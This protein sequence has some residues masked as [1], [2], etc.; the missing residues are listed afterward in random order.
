LIDVIVSWSGAA[1]SSYSFGLDDPSLPVFPVSYSGGAGF[2]IYET[3]DGAFV[4]GSGVSNC[5]W[6]N[7]Q[8]Q[9]S[10]SGVTHFN[11]A[12][13]VGSGWLT[14][15]SQSFVTPQY[16]SA[17]GGGFFFDAQGTVTYVLGVPEPGSWA[18]MLVGFGVVGGAL[19]SSRRGESIRDRVAG[20]PWRHKLGV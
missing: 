17:D 16:T 10:G 5:T 12:G 1:Y 13:Y 14:I 11:P 9:V 15:D 20:L 3:G 6:L 4:P 18:L 7:C 8:V 2:V 19:R